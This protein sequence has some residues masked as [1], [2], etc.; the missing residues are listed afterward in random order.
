[1]INSTF[2][3]RVTAGNSCPTLI[4]KNSCLAFVSG[5]NCLPSCPAL[6]K[7]PDRS[8]GSNIYVQMFDRHQMHPLSLVELWCCCTGRSS[9]SSVIAQPLLPGF[10]VACGRTPLLQRRDRVGIKPTSLF[11][12]NA[13]HRHSCRYLY[14]YS[15]FLFH[16]QFILMQ[17]VFQQDFHHIYRM[18][19]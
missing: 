17:P 13:L 12:L 14:R 18:P 1:M 6:K 10:P 16:N 11:E 19:G 2:P 5:N 7:P 8:G 4:R 3:V 9:G 15:V